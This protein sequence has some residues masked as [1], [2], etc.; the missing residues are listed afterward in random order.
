MPIIQ[1]QDYKP[2]FLFKNNHLNT[3]TPAILRK[4]NSI[5]YTRFRIETNDN[6]FIDF[7]RSSVNSSTAVIVT[8]GLEGNSNK[9]YI[10]GIAKLMNENGFDAICANLRGCS[11]EHNQLLSSYHSGKTDDLAL[12]INHSVL[13]FKYKKIILIGF[14]LGG[15][16]TLKYIGEMGKMIPDYVKLAV[17]ISVPC[18]LKSSAIQLIK[19]TN[20]IYLQRFL[21]SLKKKAIF[22]MK[23]FGIDDFKRNEILKTKNFFEFDNLFTAPIHGFENAEDYWSRCSCKQF[24]SSISIPTLIINAKDDPFLPDDCYPYFE[25]EKNPLLYLEIPKYG[26]HVGFMTSLFFKYPLWHEKRILSFINEKLN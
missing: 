17:T 20:W 1:N 24:L 19:K 2:P 11:N 7:D 4:V 13:Q 15:N 22:K 6:D 3:I 10:K 23:K 14:S 9:P 16:I 5:K 8:H 25:A 18:N 26:G 21:R 12:L